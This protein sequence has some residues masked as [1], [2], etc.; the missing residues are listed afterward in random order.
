MRRSGAS[1]SADKSRKVNNI[2]ISPKDRFF[3][4]GVYALYKYS[5]QS[6]SAKRNT[7]SD[8]RRK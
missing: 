4:A 6:P 5:N 2:V 1:S 8:A 7:S 3:Y